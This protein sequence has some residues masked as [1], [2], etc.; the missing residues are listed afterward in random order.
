MKLV[1]KS[2]QKAINVAD[3][4]QG[5]KIKCPGCSAPI[6]VPTASVRPAKVVPER[7]ADEDPEYDAGD[8]G[9]SDNGDDPWPIAMPAPARRF[10]APSAATR[11]VRQDDPSPSRKWVLPAVSITCLVV[12]FFAGR[13][14][15]KYQ[16]FSVFASAADSFAE[17]L[18]D[19]PAT[20]QPPAE[21]DA[22]AAQQQPMAAAPAAPAA[23]QIPVFEL[24]QPY[25]SGTLAI[26]LTGGSVG[27]VTLSSGLTGNFQ[28]DDHYLTLSFVVQNA[29]DRKIMTFHNKSFGPSYWQMVDDVDNV[30]RG[31][32]FGFGSKVIGAIESGEDIP[33]GEARNHIEVFTVPPPKTQSLTLTLD[34]QA[35]G[36]EGS[37]RFHIPAAAIAGFNK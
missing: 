21:R 5:K 33:P 34:T 24:N 35:F 31:I 10:P 15:M 13:E 12:G 6:T 7:A 22:Q 16:I 20:P 36:G 27:P 17:A 9:Q 19:E 3:R 25:R 2:C 8:Y 1:C 23:A 29:H 4:Y 28:T 32:D 30:I 37:I 11:E 26:V 18:S 14:Q